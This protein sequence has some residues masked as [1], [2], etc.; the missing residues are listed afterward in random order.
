MDKMKEVDSLYAP[1]YV[2][3]YWSAG[4]FGEVHCLIAS[5][6]LV[7]VEIKDSM[8]M[9]CGVISDLGHFFSDFLTKYLKIYHY[10]EKEK[11]LCYDKLKVYFKKQLLSFSCLGI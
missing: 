2:H 7:Q 11:L 9:L 5:H 6:R 1:G 3:V 4:G 8:T 10:S